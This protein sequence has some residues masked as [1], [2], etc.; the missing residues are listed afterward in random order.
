MSITAVSAYSW[1]EESRWRTGSADER[2]RD[3]ADA[4]ALLRV[5]GRRDDECVNDQ[6]TPYDRYFAPDASI[7]R[8]PR[9]GYRGI[10][11]EVS[12]KGKTVGLVY[13]SGVTPPSE[14][15]ELWTAD[16]ISEANSF[17][18]EWEAIA[19]TISQAE[20]D[21]HGMPR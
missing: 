21:E 11:A 14:T 13:L 16:A 19:R 5:G 17:L 8:A 3:H 7:R 9:A 2:T 1:P 12:Y 15:I 18:T 10:V 20:Q 4:R 6:P